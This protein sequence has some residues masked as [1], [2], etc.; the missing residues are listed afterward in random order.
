MNLFWNQC[1]PCV[2][3]KP[4]FSL[5]FFFFV[6]SDGGEEWGDHGAWVSS[7]SLDA[8]QSGCFSQG[9][10]WFSSSGA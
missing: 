8:V 9:A 2:K 5:F 1:H 7:W 10:L 3:G 4:F 6:N